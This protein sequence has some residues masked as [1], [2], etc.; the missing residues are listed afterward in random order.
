MKQLY[1]FIGI[2]SVKQ[3]DL[4]F[5]N[6]PY[7]TWFPPSFYSDDIPLESITTYHVYVKSQEG[8]V[9]ADDNT[10]DTFYQ[11]PSNL[12]YCDSYNAD[13]EAFIEQYSSPPTNVNKENTGGMIILIIYYYNI[14]LHYQIVQS[15]Y[16][17]KM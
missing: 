1:N 9:I 15:S 3:L 17:A 6:N 16:L 5:N 14:L 8:S 10:T 2:S 11:L 4:D 13:V 7:L 12:K